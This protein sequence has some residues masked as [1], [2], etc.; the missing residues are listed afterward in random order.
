M[1]PSNHTMVDAI[2]KLMYLHVICIY[3]GSRNLVLYSV[4]TF[5][6]NIQWIVEAYLFV[7][8]MVHTLK[9]FFSNFKPP[10]NT[11]LNEQTINVSPC[12]GSDLY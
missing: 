5:G 2:G 10:A 1:I 6:D 12:S 11:L 8:V 3:P 7:D 9:M 4:H